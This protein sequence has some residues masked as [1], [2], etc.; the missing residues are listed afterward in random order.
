MKHLV[1]SILFL[2]LFGFAQDKDENLLSYVICKNKGIVRTIRVEWIEAEKVCVTTY[3]KN[4]TDQN[5]GRAQN[6]SS[7]GMFLENIRTNLIKA[8]WECKD[9]SK[10]ADLHSAASL[11]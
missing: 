3:T 8:G 4:G 9:V 10:K 6:K 2:P 7:C 11:D 5:V 1:I